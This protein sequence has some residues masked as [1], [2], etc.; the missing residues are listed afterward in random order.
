MITFNINKNNKNEKWKNIKK[1]I[2][3][4]EIMIVAMNF[5]VENRLEYTSY[6]L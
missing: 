3:I 4:Y 1:N 2:I 5:S 6:M